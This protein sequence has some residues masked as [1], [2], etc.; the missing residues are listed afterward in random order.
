MS[1]QD[2]KGQDKPIQLLREYIKGSRL[3]GSYL[4][5]G[6]E[7]IGKKLVAQTLAKALNCDNQTTESCDKCVSCLK[8]ENSRHPDVHIIDGNIAGE[9]GDSIKIEYIRQMQK[10]ISLRAYE[11]RKKVFIIDNAHNLTADAANSLLKILE[12][13]PSGTVIILISAKPALLFKTITSRCK[14]M[15]FYPLGRAK[16]EDSLKKDFR[17]DNNLAHYLAYFCEGRIGRALRLKDTDILREKN[18]VIETFT[19]A[20]RAGLSRIAT[21]TRDDMRTQLNILA[22]WFRDLH[23]VKIG[24]PYQELINL[25]RKEELLK[26][27]HRY[28][29]VDLYEIMN[30]IS[31]SLLYLERNINMKLLLSNLKWSLKSEA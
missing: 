19:S 29:F 11:G 26:L 20:K 25:D 31:K 24:T 28:T 12:E 3:E 2:I 5:V 15:K 8:I 22:G 18:A 7:G 13:P 21:E 4:F 30:S 14:V 27:M 10:E 23:L 1:F 9:D 6:E 17:L 16:L